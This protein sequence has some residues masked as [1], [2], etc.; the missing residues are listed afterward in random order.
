MFNTAKKK[1]NNNNF[2]HKC[3]SAKDMKQKLKEI[4]YDSTIS[5]AHPPIL[6]LPFNMSSSVMVEQLDRI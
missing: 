4:I 1:N 6:C 5:I 2:E 3:M